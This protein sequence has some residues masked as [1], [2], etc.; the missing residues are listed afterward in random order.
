MSPSVKL[1]LKLSKGLNGFIMSILQ[2]GDRWSTEVSGDK[3]EFQVN[4]VKYYT[5]CRN[6]KG[7]KKNRNKLKSILI[8]NTLNY[9]P[10]QNGAGPHII[11]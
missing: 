7:K 4:F 8:A 6:M 11:N 10:Q 5:S 3:F 2:V 1:I 9:N